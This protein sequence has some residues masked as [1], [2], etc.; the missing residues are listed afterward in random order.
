MQ[1]DWAKHRVITLQ[2][3]AEAEHVTRKTHHIQVNTVAVMLDV[4]HDSSH[5]SI[6]DMLQFHKIFA[7]WGV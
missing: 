1:L 2:T 3:V 5:C 6:H 7:R 4:I